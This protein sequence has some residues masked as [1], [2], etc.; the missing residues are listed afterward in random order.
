MKKDGPRLIVG[1]RVLT[2]AI[3]VS[4]KPERTYGTK[5]NARSKTVFGTVIDIT[6]SKPTPTGRLQTYIIA[7]WQLGERTKRWEVR[8]EHVKPATPNDQLENPGSSD[9]LQFI[10]GVQDGAT[11]ASSTSPPSVLLPRQQDLVE[12]QDGAP[13]ASSTSIPSVLLP[14]QQELVVSRNGTAW[15]KDDKA[16]MKEING[17][18]PYREWYLGTPVDDK[19]GTNR[20]PTCNWSKLEYFQFMF[21]PKQLQLM[22]EETNKQIGIHFKPISPGE[23]MKFFGVCLLI[24]RCEF[25][26]RRSLWSTSSLSKYSAA[27]CFG[28]TGM[29]K[30]RFD[31]ILKNIRFSR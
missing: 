27:P 2:K 22:V 13:I 18:V 15:Y 11:V 3:Y 20:D 21:P 31:M 8:S 29:P 6:R 30:D 14:R 23:L 19:L 16:T 28:K 7:D 1:A 12:V 10:E 5:Y 24:T 25:A 9:D 4:K 26:D 17:F